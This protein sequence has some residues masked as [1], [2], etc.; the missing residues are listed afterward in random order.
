MTDF[1]QTASRS[2]GQDWI[3]GLFKQQAN[4]QS[5]EQL[6]N[7]DRRGAAATQYRYGNI[8]AGRQ[9][10][11]DADA[12][13]TK[14]KAEQLATTQMVVKALRAERDAGR[15]LGAAL[16]A[17]RPTLLA[18]GT[19]AGQLATIEAQVLANPA[20]LEQ[21][22]AI[23]AEQMKW[24]L[25][26]GANG[27]TVA[28]GLDP[29]KGTTRSR[30]A[31]AAPAAPEITQFG[32]INAPDRALPEGQMTGYQPGT[33][34]AQPPITG[35]EIGGGPL[36]TPGAVPSAGTPPAPPTV[37]A[38]LDTMEAITAQSESGTRER[39]GNGR[40]ITSPVGAQGMMQVMPG[41]NRDPGYGVTPARDNSDAERTRVG[42]D[43]LAAMM[44]EYGN[45]PAKAWAAYNWGPG[46]L[47]RAIAR[48]GGDWLSAAPAETQAYVA[49][50]L[51][52]LNGS[53]AQ[54]DEEGPAPQE[55]PRQ[56][57]GG[58]TLTPM[59]TPAAR[60]AAEERAYQRSRD[61]QQDARSERTES[62]TELR[63]EEGLDRTN[64]AEVA[65]LRREFRTDKEVVAFRE[66]DN[67]YR[68]MATTVNDPTPE[69]DIALIFSFMK[70]LDPTS[71][72][73]EGEFA[74]AGNS[75]SAFERAG[76]LYNRVLNG[77]RL[78]PR[79]RQSFLAQAGNIRDSRQTRFD[80]IRGEFQ[81]EADILG[82]PAQRVVGGA[83]APPSEGAN[84]NR[85]P[86]PVPNVPLKLWES[87]TP[88]Q[89]NYWRANPPR[90]PNGSPTN[91][92]RI[93]ENEA[94][95]AAAVPPGGY[96]LRRDGTIL[97]KPQ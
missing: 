61:A 95:S 34:T 10:T 75:G 32:I 64:R 91:P 30:L 97:R 76:V 17:Y 42:R 92:Y 51:R 48:N 94:S 50:N 85:R 9:L 54:G 72:V 15:D 74:T 19:D 12:A 28:V 38:P 6:A 23:T 36:F 31:Y 39:D 52:A 25:R 7:G 3:N 35:S 66:T 47:D 67:A 18:M 49:K 29:T 20:F 4:L 73:R 22:D 16:A 56:L 80:E 81:A 59:E 96:A 88:Q 62:R 1:L 82:I 26:A 71:T 43:Y 8:D 83:T 77:Q 45:D 33:S 27:D 63:F 78:N 37:A 70:V 57:G 44:R 68:T 24:E 55:G 14:T 11:A 89:Q 60:A 90:G 84:A 79:Q 93:G 86:S 58:Y 53:E 41:T 40:L 87:S 69:G 2:N 5:G 65:R 21:I 13:A 46:N